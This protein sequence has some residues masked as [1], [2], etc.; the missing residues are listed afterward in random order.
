MSVKL[1]DAILVVWPTLCGCDAFA[2][3]AF[4]LDNAKVII[5]CLCLRDKLSKPN[6]QV[7]GSALALI[8]HKAHFHCATVRFC[9][10]STI[11]LVTTNLAL[12]LLS[13]VSVCLPLFIMLRFT[14]RCVRRPCPYDLPDHVIVGFI[15]IV[16]C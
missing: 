4:E 3:F 1:I 13:L 15:V 7:K 5:H 2:F 8:N 16:G 6:A 11:V 14:E 10:E 9:H 12:N